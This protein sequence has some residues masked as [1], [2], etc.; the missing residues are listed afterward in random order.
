MNMAIVA[1]PIAVG[2][3]LDVGPG[4][5]RK[6]LTITGSWTITSVIGG[7][8]AVRHGARRGCG[9][10]LLRSLEARSGGRGVPGVRHPVG[11]QGGVRHMTPTL[12]SEGATCPGEF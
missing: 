11:G 1:A 7:L 2:S 5:T 8:R 12:L 3:E 10:I 4:I 6:Q 9:Q